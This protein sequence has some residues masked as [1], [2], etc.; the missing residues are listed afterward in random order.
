MAWLVLHRGL[1][2][3]LHAAKH[4][5]VTRPPRGPRVLGVLVAASDRDRVGTLR[6][7]LRA[8]ADFEL[9]D[10]P[11]MKKYRCD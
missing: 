8:A 11:R 10:S 7:V 4:G 3:P 5:S 1:E 2:T 9:D 6:P